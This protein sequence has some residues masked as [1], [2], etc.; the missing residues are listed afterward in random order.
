RKTSLPADAF[1]STEQST[2]VRS[3]PPANLSPTAHFLFRPGFA[4]HE[5]VPPRPFSP[6]APCRPMSLQPPDP[7]PR[8]P[9]YSPRSIARQFAVAP[10]S[11]SPWPPTV[12]IAGNRIHNIDPQRCTCRAAR[13]LPIALVR[14][15]LPAL[16]G[17]GLLAHSVDQTPSA[18]A[19]RCP[20]RPGVARTPMSSVAKPAT[21]CCQYR[22]PPL[23]PRPSARLAPPS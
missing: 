3:P 20:I 5:R 22:A 4:R 18:A 6:T 1:D 10:R 23:A 21:P 14:I 19:P 7:A 16:V 17:P 15:F 11:P 8:A 9:R 13:T 2:L 12:P